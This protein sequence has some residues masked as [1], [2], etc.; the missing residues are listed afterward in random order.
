MLYHFIIVFIR[1]ANGRDTQQHN[2][3]LNKKNMT[4]VEFKI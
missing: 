4:S 3:S 1:Q 2:N